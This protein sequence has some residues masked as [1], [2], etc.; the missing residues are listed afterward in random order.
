MTIG[1]AECLFLFHFY[2]CYTFHFYSHFW[3]NLFFSHSEPRACW[4]FVEKLWRR[5]I[6]S[7]FAMCISRQIRD[8]SGVTITR[9][10]APRWLGVSDETAR[11]PFLCLDPSPGAS[12][13]LPM[14][15]VPYL[16]LTRSTVNK[17]DLSI[18]RST[19]E[20]YVFSRKNYLDYVL[21]RPREEKKVK[22]KQDGDIV[23][24]RWRYRRGLAIS[25][26][27]LPARERRK[28]GTGEVYTTA[29][30]NMN[31]INISEYAATMITHVRRKLLTTGGWMEK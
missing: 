1:Q 31:V 29:V 7:A 27:E 10:V 16:S 8:A 30:N 28:K 11:F 4:L 6:V 22:G 24:R 15:D 17:W 26:V 14:S 21:F 20:A 13:S 12:P 2:F 9:G 3:K 23:N 25:L 5:I 19:T 18:F